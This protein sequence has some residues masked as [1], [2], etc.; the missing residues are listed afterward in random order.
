[1]TEVIRRRG[2]DG[3][4]TGE[5]LVR[6]PPPSVSCRDPHRHPSDWP[7]HFRLSGSTHSFNTGS[8]WL[9]LESRILVD[10]SSFP[11][12]PAF[13][14]G[15]GHIQSGFRGHGRFGPGL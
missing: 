9:S 15:P 12:G 3:R 8:T 10:Q 7:Y 13:D 2:E 6:A 5:G 14:V 1:M 4:P 11:P